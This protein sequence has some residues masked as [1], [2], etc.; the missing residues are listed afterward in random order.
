MESETMNE[1]TMNKNAM[2]KDAK[3]E[4][5]NSEERFV[6]SHYTPGHFDSLQ[7]RRRLQQQHPELCNQR[8]W[9][10]HRIAAAAAAVTIFVTAY[11][12]LSNPWSSENQPV[13]TSDVPVKVA[14]VQ[15][16][17]FHFDHTPL[18]EVLR[19]LEQ[20][21]GVSLVASDTLNPTTRQPL[22]LTA[23]FEADSLSALLPL[24]EEALGVTLQQ[25]PPLP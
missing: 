20:V 21:Y 23:D 12:L 1:E 22:R 3:N 5:M 15:P 8:Q 24:I 11:A 25:G 9:H 2:K 4:E 6:L 7:A 14:K 19:Q 16:H 17:S 18:S 13:T 10:W